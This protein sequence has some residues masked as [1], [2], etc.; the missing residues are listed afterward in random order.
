MRPCVDRDYGWGMIPVRVRLGGTEW[1]T[2]MFPKDGAYV[3]PIKDAAR[4][5][6]GLAA[7]DVVTVALTVRR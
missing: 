6:D 1:T 7:D 2:A 4:R 3:V 5:S